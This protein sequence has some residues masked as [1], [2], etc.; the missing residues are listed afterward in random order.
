MTLEQEVATGQWGIVSR[1]QLSA[2]GMSPEAIRWRAARQWRS[3]L[4]GVY[5]IE[6]GRLGVHQAAMAAQLYV[7]LLYTSRCV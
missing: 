6:P 1:A 7:C 3:L 2:A 5:A 4:P